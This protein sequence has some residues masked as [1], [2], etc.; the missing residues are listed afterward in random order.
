VVVR[1]RS[2]AHVRIARNPSGPA[3]R[4][5]RKEAS[6]AATSVPTR[7]TL[8]GSFS[9]PW[10]DRRNQI[11]LSIVG[12]QGTLART[13]PCRS[14]CWQYQSPPTSSGADSVQ[15]LRTHLVAGAC[16][17]MCGIIGIVSH[18]SLRTNAYDL[19]L[20][21]YAIWNSL[22]GRVGWVPFIGHSIFSEHFMP[23]LLLI[24][25]AYALWQSPTTLILIQVLSV[26]TAALL[27]LKLSRLERV[28]PFETCVLIF[29]FLA[30]R[31]SFLAINSP[32][33]PEAFQ[34]ALVLALV[35]AWRLSR[36]RL[37]WL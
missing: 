26:G 31:P 16:T 20:F 36:M 15:T 9:L 23:I 19:S 3:P 7:G 14:R 37:Y 30:S 32:F 33:N 4:L 8:F 12:W 6:K 5:A 27:L 28:K 29:V 25:P 10:R 17:T 11:R 34:P 2:R 35:L 13:A 21:D 18:Y 24:L 1:N 22:N